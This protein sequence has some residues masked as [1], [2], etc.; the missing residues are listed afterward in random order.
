MQSVTEPVADLRRPATLDFA[1]ALLLLATVVLHVVAMAPVYFAGSGSLMSQPDQAAMYAVLSA[2]WALALAIGFTGPHRTPVAAALSVGVAVTELGFRVADLGDALKYGTGTVGNG[3]WIM[4]AAWV[5]GAVAAVTAVLAARSRHGRPDSEAP[6]PAGD[7]KIDWAPS[8]AGAPQVNPY[9]GGTEPGPAAEPGGPEEP[10]TG[11]TGAGS[12]EEPT[13]E[14]ATGDPTAAVPAQDAPTV[15]METASQSADPAGGLPAPQGGDTSMLPILPEEEEDPHE[16]LAWSALVVVLAL[17]VAGAFLPA[18]DHAT[19]VST[20]TGQ[21]VT[22][23]LGNAFKGQPW[24]QVV[25]T[26]LAAV[27]LLVVPVVAIRLRNKAV[28]AAATVGSLLV[29]T[30]QFVAAVVQVDQPVPPSDFGIN[31]SQVHDLGLQLSLKL[32]GWF[33]LDALAAYALFATVMV[34]ATLR[35]VHE[36]SAGTAPSAPDRRSAA[37]PFAS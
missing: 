13:A 17:V 11:R 26:V 27:A 16:R 15:S 8:D 20:Q 10:V 19:A 29:L 25:G 37:M 3:F 34:W 23:D 7:W 30:S 5:V 36:N 21:S 28:G 32:T 6:A 4:E 24:Q 14:M 2:S 9:S 18:W 1:A 35:V 12:P 33:T 31:G 22:R